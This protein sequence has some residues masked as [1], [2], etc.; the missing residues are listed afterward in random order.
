MHL[1]KVQKNKFISKFTCSY[2]F[3]L[4]ERI[5]I[6]E[7]KEIDKTLNKI[8]KIIYSQLFLVSFTLFNLKY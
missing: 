6:L 2:I 1:F 8:F 3:E 7:F 4:F 5:D